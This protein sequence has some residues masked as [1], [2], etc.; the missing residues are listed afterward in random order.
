MRYEPHCSRSGTLPC[1]TNERVDQGLCPATSERECQPVDHVARESNHVLFQRI[2][3]RLKQEICGRA[4]DQEVRGCFVWVRRVA[5]CSQRN[6]RT[7]SC[8]Q[9]SGNC[10]PVSQACLCEP[11]EGDVHQCSIGSACCMLM[12][13]VCGGAQIRPG[14]RSFRNHTY[15]DNDGKPGKDDHHRQRPYDPAP[16]RDRRQ[17]IQEV[18]LGVEVDACTHEWYSVRRLARAELSTMHRTHPVCHHTV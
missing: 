7:E 11:A 4:S 15:G 9:M 3:F 14:G 18:Q 1:N 2:L 10:V 16:H 17:A 8:R 13:T 6:R 12:N 5:I